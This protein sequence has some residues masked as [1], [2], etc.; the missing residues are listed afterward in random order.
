MTLFF[1]HFAPSSSSII[2]AT[3]E[4]GVKITL[5]EWCAEESQG[6]D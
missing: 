6:L 5:D 4:V 3:T 1:L 2:L